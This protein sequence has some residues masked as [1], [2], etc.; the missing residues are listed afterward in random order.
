MLRHQDSLSAYH[1]IVSLIADSKRYLGDQPSSVLHLAGV[2]GVAAIVTRAILHVIHKLIP[3]LVHFRED[4]S[5]ILR[6]V[7]S[8]LPPMLYTSPKRPLFNT[9]QMASQ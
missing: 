4:R 9:V 6:L 1:L 5:V 3:W 2:D 8:L 7:I